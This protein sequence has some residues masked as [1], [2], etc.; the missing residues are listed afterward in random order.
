MQEPQPGM[1]AHPGCIIG[2]H[3][4]DAAGPALAGKKAG[5]Y[6]ARRTS[7][8]ADD[9]DDPCD[10]GSAA[11]G[12]ICETASAAMAAG[13]SPVGESTGSSMGATRGPIGAADVEVAASSAD[14][15]NCGSAAGSS[16]PRGVM[17][18]QE[19]SAIAVSVQRTIRGSP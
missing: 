1:G 18:W 12:E 16:V 14:D 13:V 9:D 19:H 17:V 11:E 15:T 6:E 2:A 4:Y 7:V 8:V 10:P 5:V 3:P